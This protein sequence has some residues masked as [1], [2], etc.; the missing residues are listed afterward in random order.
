MLGMLRERGPAT[1]TLLA[2]R[3][4]Q[5]TGATSYHLR[6]L[7]SYGF[8]E[9]QA[10]KGVGRERWWRAVSDRTIFEGPSARHDPAEAEA[11]MRA[12]AAQ[13]SDRVDSWISEATSM[14]KEWERCPTISDWR[15][16]L[17]PEECRE[18]NEEIFALAQRYRQDGSTAPAEARRVFFQVQLLPFIQEPA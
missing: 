5:S 14:P 8:V 1:A 4:G 16:K 6:Q 11:Y 18:L 3:L 15:L 2:Q 13:Y 12:V 7:A 9:E 10:G 17:T